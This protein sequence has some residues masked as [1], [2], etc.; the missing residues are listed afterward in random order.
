[1][2]KVKKGCQA[3][4]LNRGL[5]L[6]VG[7]EAVNQKQVGG[8]FE[9]FECSIVKCNP[10]MCTD[11]WVIGCHEAFVVCEACSVISRRV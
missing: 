6:F 11:T 8:G 10:T 9:Q 2:L 4:F 7:V 1:M 3:G 5:T